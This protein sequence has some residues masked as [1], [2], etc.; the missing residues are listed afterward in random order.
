M[1]ELRAAR[2][3]I[4]RI[5]GE[6]ARL[7]EE[8]MAAAAEIALW[9]REKGRPV[10]DPAREREVLD[11]AA[12]RLADPAL[13][14]RF[15]A[16]MEALMAQS[17]EYQKELLAAGRAGTS[18]ACPPDGTGSRQQATGNTDAAMNTGDGSLNTGDGSLCSGTQRTVPCVGVPCVPGSASSLKYPIFLERDILGKA[19]SRL[20]LD[21]RVCLVTDD[22]VP[23]EY[24]QALA[25]QCREATVFTI[26]QGEASKSPETL[27]ALLEAMLRAGLTRADCVAALGGG[28]VG[29]LAGLAA[30]LYMRG[31][32]WYNVPT[33]LLA[34][35]DSSVGGKTAVDLGGVK[36]AAGAFWQPRAVLIDP[37]VLKTLPPRHLANGLA[38]AVKMALTHDPA[39]FARFE[40]PAGCGPMEDVIAACLR[41]KTA[42]V[43]ADEREAGLRRVLNLGHTLGHGLEAAAGGRL[44]HGEAVALGMLPMCAPAVRTRLRP[45][46]DR[47]G[48]PTS[49]NFDLDIDA[50]MEAIAHDKKSVDGGIEIVTVPEIG[51]F[52]FQRVSLTELRTLLREL[53]IAP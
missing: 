20:D 53:S 14:P 45:V 52:Q 50:A 24:A 11:R 16:V 35:V 38:E 49:V 47:L 32:D 15:A 10:R 18:I 31:I 46:L 36:N 27:T 9:K 40:D 34:M 4:D 44:L 21:R 22:G 8:R 39:L 3:R 17:R 48:L 7:F 43:A 1:D 26:P 19:A 5:D 2:E 41:I 37:D 23:A 33:T 29:D 13:R 6:L 25:A 42:V 28:V 30:A 12:A 51:T